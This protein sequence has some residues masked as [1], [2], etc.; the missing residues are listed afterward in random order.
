MSDEN[1]RHTDLNKENVMENIGIFSGFFNLSY[2][3]SPKR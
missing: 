3:E 2:E 1:R